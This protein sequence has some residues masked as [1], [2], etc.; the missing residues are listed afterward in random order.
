MYARVDLF[1]VEVTSGKHPPKFHLQNYNDVQK[2]Q[3]VY[4]YSRTRGYL[5]T[6]VIVVIM[7]KI[8]DEVMLKTLKT[9]H[10]PMCTRTAL[11]GH[12]ISFGSWTASWA[13]LGHLGPSWDHLAAILRPS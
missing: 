5:V 10:L 6:Y 4:R 7:L 1:Y 13:I 3:Y 2:T 9:L 11:R 8:L 12:S